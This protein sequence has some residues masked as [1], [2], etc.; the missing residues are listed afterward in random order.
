MKDITYAVAFASQNGANTL[1][2][3]YE[4]CGAVAVGL[5]CKDKKIA[6]QEATVNANKIIVNRTFAFL[7]KSGNIVKVSRI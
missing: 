2:I 7:V 4:K 5:Y 6:V 1:D 3:Y